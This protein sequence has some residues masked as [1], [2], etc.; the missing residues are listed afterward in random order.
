MNIEPAEQKVPIHSKDINFNVKIDV[1]EDG[2]YGLSFKPSSDSEL[3]ALLINRNYI[4]ILSDGYKKIP[5]KTKEQKEFY[6]RILNADYVLK[7]LFHEQLAICIDA[8]S[9]PAEPET[10]K[11]EVVRQ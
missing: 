2:S 6:K 5:K 4:K 3:V 11:L 1:Y 9:K 8:W 10:V 7:Q